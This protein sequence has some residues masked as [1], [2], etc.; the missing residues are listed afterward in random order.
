M[1]F[2]QI[3]S[4]AIAA[5]KAR[6]DQGIP[7]LS[8][9]PEGKLQVRTILRNCGRIDSEQINH[10]IVGGGYSG[11]AKALKMPPGEVIAEIG[12]SGLRGRGG[13]GFPAAAKWAACRAAPGN[14]K[15]MICNAAE[16]DPGAGHIHMLL[17]NDPH[18]VLEGMII[19]AYAVGAT[20]GYIVVNR[21]NEAAVKLLRAALAQAENCN[22][23]GGSILDYGF[24]FQV[25]LK[26]LDD[27]FLSGEETALLCAMEGRQPMPM[28]YKRPPF[29]AVSGLAGRPTC[30]NSAETLANVSVIMQKGAAWY[31]GC[32]TENSKGTKILSLNGDIA[33]PGIIEVPMGTTLRQIVYEIGGGVRDGKELKMLQIG[34][35]AGGCFPV[36]ALDLPLDYECF[37]AEDLIMGS[38]AVTVAAGDKCTVAFVKERLSFL[39]NASCGKCV[40]CR[41]GTAQIYEILTDIMEGRGKPDDLELLEELAAGMR[42]GSLCNLG[43]T[44][45]LPLLTTL[46]HFRDEYETHIRRKRC[47]ALVCKK[48]ITYH[49]LPGQCRGCGLCLEHCPA[50][51]IRGGAQMV[52]VIDGD[53]CTKCGICLDLCPSEYNAVVKAGGVKPRTPDEPIPVGSWHGS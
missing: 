2:A 17:E 19:G 49:I 43:K 9:L 29:P 31:A 35:P 32:G 39:H 30:I 52:H 33:N 26:E 42:T 24:S 45:A 6:G 7:V 28:P 16:G 34:G 21:K 37:V 40:F 5:W 11:L 44:A 50:G 23:L 47:P 14:E 8:C 1:D 18:S 38:G 53:E 12:K 22:L 15:Y 4:N 10:Y 3:Q 20:A 27:A 46:K 51:A 48:F 25:E 13:A 36:S 41:E